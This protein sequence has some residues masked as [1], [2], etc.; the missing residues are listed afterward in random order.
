MHET[1]GDASA[2]ARLRQKLL[3]PKSV[4]LIGASDDVTKTAARPLRFLRQAG[5]SGAIYPINP[6][7]DTVLGERA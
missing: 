7:R 6:R 4:A 5:F 2:R 3:S 1:G